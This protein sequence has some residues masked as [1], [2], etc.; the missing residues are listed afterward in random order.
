MNETIKTILARRTIRAF[1]PEQ[2]NENDLSTI[3]DT[4][5]FAATAKGLQPWHF[6]V[7]QN[8]ELMGKIVEA[9]KKKILAGNDEL[10]KS[11]AQQP[12]FSNFHN[13]PTVI[14]VSGDE[15]FKFATADC[16]NATQNMA[17]AA[18]SLGLGS[19]Y[20]A[21]FLMAFATDAKDDLLKQLEIP[22]SHT[23][24]FA[25]ALGYAAAAPPERIARKEGIVN[26]IR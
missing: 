4:A 25:I 8:T 10:L 13:A 22:A 11:K 17:V 7:L 18:Q 3:L 21:S 1:K 12:G 20:M 26:Y 2:I 14:I 23:P 16:A 9:C 24:M 19:C 15:S 5:K 6:T